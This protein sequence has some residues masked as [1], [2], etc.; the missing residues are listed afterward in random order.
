MRRSA[1]LGLAGI[2]LGAVVLA[3][4]PGASAAD[5]QTS[6]VTRE[7]HA[8]NR[9]RVATPKTAV[10]GTGTT[11]ADF[12][13][14][15]MDDVAGAAYIFRLQWSPEF[16]GNETVIVRYSS[17]PYTDHLTSQFINGCFGYAVAAGNFNGDRYDDL[18]IGAPCEP[19][20]ATDPTPAGGVWIVPGGPG[21]LAFANTVHIDQDTA[22][23]PGVS[24]D[25]DHFGGSLAAGDL[26]GDSRDD[27]AV[28]APQE[29]LGGDRDAGS[30]TVLRGGA[31]GITTSGAVSLNQDLASVPGAAEFQ[32]S[33]GAS[34]AIGRVDRDAYADLVIGATGE[35]E[36]V[37]NGSGMVTLMRGAATGVASSGATAVTGQRAA[38]ASGQAHTVFDYFGRT[39]TV[40][41]TNGDGYGEVIVGVPTTNAGTTV[42]SG[43]VAVFAGRSTGLSAT[44]IRVL[45]QD[46]AGVPGGREAQDH[47]GA[48]VDAGD[49]TGDGRADLL[50]GVPG[51][52]LGGA[53][54]AGAVV[55]LRGSASGLTGTG[56][57]AWDQG[58]GSVPGAAESGD[59]FGHVVALLNLDGRGGLDAVVTSPGE[60]IGGEPAEV[61]AGSVTTFGGGSSGLSPKTAWSG[62]SLRFADFYLD[63]YGHQIAERSSRS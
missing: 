25:G 42:G 12:D 48:S 38:A 16:P 30:V 24:E 13:G 58:H 31:A 63:S 4:P 37:D 2:V 41:D 46:T 49:V 56:S 43:A 8:V 21:G 47:F 6:S 14:D 15:G 26:T 35:N 32:D 59:G 57:Q 60:K 20:S 55:L 44:G 39:A 29:D 36:G 22:G 19:D 1:T 28:G 27:L 50:V 62:A 61:T 3:V 5:V 11:R 33:F 51:E 9:Y 34:V 18:V 40:A 45:H 54:D 17:A 52:D 23:V 10:T 7:G 53:V